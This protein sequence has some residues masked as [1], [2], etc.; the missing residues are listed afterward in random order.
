MIRGE[1]V[2]DQATLRALSDQRLKVVSGVEK[3]VTRLTI[4]LLRMVKL[5]LSDDV[6]HVRS[7]R[8]RRSINATFVGSGAKTQGQ[9]GTNVPYGRVHEYGLTVT[10]EEHMRMMRKAW[11]KSLM[12]PKQVVVHQHTVHYPERSFL[13]SALAEMGPEIQAELDAFKLTLR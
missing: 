7:G 2:G 9:V 6:L 13:R 3:V 10:V 1:V 4:K 12:T 5:K 8:L 11:G